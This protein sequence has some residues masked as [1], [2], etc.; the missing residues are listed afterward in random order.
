M[1]YIVQFPRNLYRLSD[2]TRTE[3]AAGKKMWIG[4]SVPPFTWTDGITRGK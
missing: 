2:C 4:G 1:F 3:A